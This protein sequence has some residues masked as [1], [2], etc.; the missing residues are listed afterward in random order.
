MAVAARGRARRGRGICDVISWKENVAT[1]AC[2]H[3]MQH[4]KSA[5]V[6]HTCRAAR[7]MS[8]HFNLSSSSEGESGD[9]E[10]E[11]ENQQQLSIGSGGI[12]SPSATSGDGPG[13]KASASTGA[14]DWGGGESDRRDS[15]NDGGGGE[16]DDEIDW[17]DAEDDDSLAKAGAKRKMPMQGITIDF[18]SG[19]EKK[20]DDDEDSEETAKKKRRKKTR[21]INKIQGLPPHLVHLV[22]NIH[23]SHML[24]LSSRAMF[25]SSLCSDDE[26][27]HLAHSLLPTDFVDVTQSSSKNRN[28]NDPIIPSED[29]ARQVLAWFFELVND[30]ES[31]RRRIRQEN[32]AMGAP[33]Q[34]RGRGGGS[35]GG[36]RGRSGRRGS[37]SAKKSHYGNSK[38]QTSAREGAGCTDQSRLA[39][40]LQYYSPTNDL[41]PDFIDDEQR[42][43]IGGLAT[44][45]EKAQI[46]VLLTRSLGWRVR[47]VTAMQPIS[48]ELTVN[49]PLFAGGL[50]DIFLRVMASGNTRALQKT[51]KSKTPKK[52][53]GSEDADVIDLAGD[54]EDDERKDDTS[55]NENGIV[56][57]NMYQGNSNLAWAEI[58]CLPTVNRSKRKSPASCS[59]SSKPSSSTARWIHVDCER[60]VA[61][62]PSVVEKILARIKSGD[63]SAPR[64]RERVSYVLGVEHNSF[65]TFATSDDIHLF[66]RV[67]DV[68]RRYAGAWSQTLRLRGASGQQ[69]VKSGGKCVDSWWDMALRKVNRLAKRRAR[70]FLEAGSGEGGEN[71]GGK[72]KESSPQKVSSR[73]PAYSVGKS[74][75]AIV[76][77]DSSDS[78]SEDDRKPA[79]S[80][81][82]S[83]ASNL[84]DEDQHEN[85]E[86]KELA[87]SAADEAIPTSKAA[88]K[89]HPLYALASNLNK[90]EVIDPAGKKR[91]VGI[92][93]GELIYR[94]SD[95]SVALTAKKWLYEGRKVKEN[96]L[97]KPAKKVKARKRS[98]P[99]TFR[100][101]TS[102][103]VSDTSEQKVDDESY[104]DD[105]GMDW[106]YGRWQTEKWGPEPVG[107]D[108]EIP[109]NEYKNV[110]LAL[111]N[112]GLVHLEVR[113]MAKVAKKLAI[114][115]APCLLGFEGH[116]GN[117][118]PTIR[119]IVVHQHNADLLRCAY[120]EWESQAVEQEHDQRRKAI[121]GRWKRL[122]VGMLTKERLDRQYGGEENK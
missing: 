53:L 122:I 111:I 68:T 62:H 12:A 99:K 47:Y 50:K 25:I 94:R 121:Y 110:E 20:D 91:I 116:G 2:S 93:K 92:F 61:D 3:I 56:G 22:Q 6:T 18:G 52:N 31:R 113:G 84:L 37:N 118:T 7:T 54:S 10:E 82:V 41:D 120:T 103:G 88:F 102:Y 114:P 27:L 24:C 95:I 119:G 101:L 17:E 29:I 59:T 46:L 109:V 66:C 14:F 57:A 65:T 112:P 19:D 49:H 32:A 9:E 80:V 36:G 15:D 87:A 79:A 28:P 96:E 89:K 8:F 55:S 38:S 21:K 73:S 85:A 74:E 33:Q 35:H 23:Q 106:I 63:E 44:P 64:T 30:V 70:C 81:S 26:L 69:I 4:H 75:D 67:T 97:S 78:E 108:D 40:L 39:N 71:N 72:K 100:A 43:A 83:S 42:D 86:K 107:P 11:I 51:K 115:Y 16:D 90:A 77:G 34:L 1:D 76:I 58:L 117:R 45:H 5:E 104:V 105:D 48:K 60:K 98:A 13:E